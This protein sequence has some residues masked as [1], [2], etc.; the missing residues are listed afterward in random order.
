MRTNDTRSEVE[1]VADDCNE[2]LVGLGSRAISVDVD[3]QR[4]SN[5]NSIR[6]LDKCSA[7]ETRSNERLG[8]INRRKLTT[9]MYDR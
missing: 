5:T 4:L 1:V 8:W 6:E 2:L 9:V 7:S 3:R